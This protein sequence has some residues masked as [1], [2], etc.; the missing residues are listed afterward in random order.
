M[1]VWGSGGGVHKASDATLIPAPLRSTK[2]TIFRRG[3][4]RL[5]YVVIRDPHSLLCDAI[6]VRGNSGRCCFF[7]LLS[8]KYHSFVGDFEWLVCCFSVSIILLDTLKETRIVV[9]LF[10]S[11]D[12]EAPLYCMRSFILSISSAFN[13]FCITLVHYIPI[14]GVGKERRVE[15]GPLVTPENTA[16]VTGTTLKTTGPVPVDSRH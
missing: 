2:P 6:S 5:G 1:D 15:L 3:W 4:K 10:L 13:T 9:V 14:V 12:V 8:F 11:V 7:R 16:P